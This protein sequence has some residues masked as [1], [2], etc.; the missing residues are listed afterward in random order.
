[1]AAGER[2]Q[3][4]R[5]RTGGHD[6]T[7]GEQQEKGR[8]SRRIGRACRVLDGDADR[9]VHPAERVTECE[10]QEQAEENPA[11]IPVEPEAHRDADA[12]HDR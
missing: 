5:Q 11:G 3:P 12:D 8:A 1:M 2:L 6:G 10:D 7:A 4:T 9:C